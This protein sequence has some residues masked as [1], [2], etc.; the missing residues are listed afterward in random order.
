[1]ADS[2]PSQGF[3]APSGPPAN[4]PSAATN[5]DSYSDTTQFWDPGFELVIRGN[6]YMTLRSRSSSCERKFH[7][8]ARAHRLQTS[9]DAWSAATS[10][11][12]GDPNALDENQGRPRSSP[13]V[14][15]ITFMN[16]HAM[17]LMDVTDDAGESAQSHSTR[18]RFAVFAR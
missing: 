9:G 6:L 11:V 14:A 1:M 3:E 5:Q 18:L 4:C 10:R 8:A 7:T 12:A 15:A 2:S 17:M 16:P 13:N